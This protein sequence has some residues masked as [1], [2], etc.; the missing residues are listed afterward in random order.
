MFIHHRCQVSVKVFAQR[1]QEALRT[2]NLGKVGQLKELSVLQP[3]V[4]SAN[5]N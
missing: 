4:F 1:F 3:Q 5:N 2:I